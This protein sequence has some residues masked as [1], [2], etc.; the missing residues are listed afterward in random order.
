V[1]LFLT[2]RA[3]QEQICFIESVSFRSSNTVKF[4]LFQH[5]LRRKLHNEELHNLYS[6]PNLIRQI[7]SRRI[8]GQ[9]MWHVWETTKMCTRFWCGTPKERDHSED[10]GV[11]EMMGSEWILGK[12]AGGVWIGLDWFRIGTGGELL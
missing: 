1:I 2:N 7:K 12:L 9:S 10:Q 5:I 6:S 3:T 11:G 4:L 8:S